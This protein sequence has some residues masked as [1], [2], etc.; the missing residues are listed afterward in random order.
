M[1]NP[2]DSLP[3]PEKTRSRE[4]NLLGAIA[5]L[6]EIPDYPVKTLSRKENYLKYIAEHG[7]GGGEGEVKS[8]NGK[9]GVV[10]LKADDIE[11]KNTLSI[12][13]NLERIDEE[14]GRLED[15]KQGL[16]TAGSN[17]SIVNNVISATGGGAPTAAD[18]D[19]VIDG[20]GDITVDLNQANDTLLIGTHAKTVEI[21]GVPATAT[22][23]TLTEEQLAALLESDK[24]VLKFNNE[25]YF[26][27][28]NGHEAGIRG[29]SHSGV[30]NSVFMLKNITVTLNTRGWVLTTQE[31]SGGGS[32]PTVVQTIGTSTTDVMSQKAVTDTIFADGGTGRQVAIGT[33]NPQSGTGTVAIGYASAV[34]GNT[35]VAVGSN[36]SSEYGSVALGA[37]ARN[38]NSYEIAIGRDAQSGARSTVV[39][40]PETTI[41]G[42]VANYPGSIALGSCAGSNITAAGMMDI[43]SALATYGYNSTN[44]RLLTGVHDGINAHDALTVGQANAL[45]DAINSAMNTSIPH[46]GNAA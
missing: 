44:Y 27:N 38:K 34:N 15:E 10:V 32:G 20:T 35:G 45:I 33:S 21:T 37:G 9:T 7:G 30:E 40:V 41:S 24:S 11:V 6:N 26:L 3:Y 2:T 28:D 39:I 29:Y 36:A 5:G 14:L 18:L 4:E 19:E 31:V 16:L 17:I 42:T 22:S 23:G 25:I 8:V 1:A 12:Q 13:D 46:I 43:G